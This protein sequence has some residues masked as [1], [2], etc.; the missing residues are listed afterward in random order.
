MDADLR[1]GYLAAASQPELS[2]RQV[3]VAHL[4]MALIVRFTSTRILARARSRR[5]QSIVTPYRTWV[6]SSV[7]ITLSCLSPIA[8][9]AESF[10]ANAL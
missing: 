2:Q 7:A 9:T 4:K 10:A 8:W 1:L 5:V 6:I 3:E